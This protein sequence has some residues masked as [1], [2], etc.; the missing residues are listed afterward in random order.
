MR[1]HSQWEGVESR[2]AP[3]PRGAGVGASPFFVNRLLERV[4]GR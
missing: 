3:S 4:A 1:T 2:E